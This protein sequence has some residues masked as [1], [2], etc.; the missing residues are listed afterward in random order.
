MTY[1]VIWE[2]EALTQAERLAKRDPDGVRQ[3]FTTVDRLSRNP[4]PRGAFGS[5]DMLRIH[6]GAYRVLYEINDR[7]VRV[8]VIHLGRLR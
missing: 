8:S 2:P 5:S 3:V 6:V 1:E 7:Q 4:R